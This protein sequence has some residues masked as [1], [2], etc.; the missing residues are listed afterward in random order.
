MV[1]INDQRVGDWNVQCDLCGVH[2]KASQTRM[3]WTNTRRCYGPGT[4]NCWEPRHPQDFVRGV[5]DRQAR[6]F[7]RPNNI[8]FLPLACPDKISVERGS[9]LVFNVLANDTYST[10]VSIK[11]I[12]IPDPA[13]EGTITYTDSA[14]AEQTV[15]ADA[16][17][18]AADFNAVTFTPAVG[19]PDTL[20]N[21]FYE[22]TDEQGYTSKSY[23]CTV[24]TG[25]DGIATN[26]FF[27]LGASD[28]EMSANATGAISSGDRNGDSL[29][30]S[31]FDQS[32][33]VVE[34]VLQQLLADGL[35][36]DSN[37]QIASFESQISATPTAAVPLSNGVTNVFTPITDFQAIYDAKAAAN[38][39]F[40]D[41]LS[42]GVD[43]G[44]LYYA[45]ALEAADTFFTANQV[46]SNDRNLVYIIT[47]TAGLDSTAEID[48]WVETLVNDHS[49]FIETLYLSGSKPGSLLAPEYIEVK[50][51]SLT[52]N[53]DHAEGGT[54]E[55]TD[56]ATYSA[57]IAGQGSVLRPEIVTT[58]VLVELEG[59]TGTL[60]LEDGDTL[61][62]E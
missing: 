52:L 31:L 34:D 41:N 53:N 25:V 60:L 7:T 1:E 50:A 8:H 9:N 54:V 30:N 51:V 20:P 23:L 42:M 37:V 45:T 16:V 44:V 38:T 57:Y 35:A 28:G 18:L 33:T 14:A 36:T 4:T 2:Y 3:M 39:W 21:Y 43:N 5:V 12:S 6:P 27:A 49:V 11:W 48:P 26:I 22:I 47:S 17:I 46:S 32:L 15:V 24:V 40:G 55:Y 29:S 19:A 62:L 10:L 13:T 61:I 59:G 56:A 58:P